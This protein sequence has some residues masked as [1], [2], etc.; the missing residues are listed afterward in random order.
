MLRKAS[1]MNPEVQGSSEG[2]LAA[3]LFFIGRSTKG[4]SRLQV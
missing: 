4:I 2:Q 1:E 3:V